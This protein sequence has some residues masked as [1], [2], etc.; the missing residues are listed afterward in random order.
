[1]PSLSPRR[2]RSDAVRCTTIK[3]N[4]ERCG[5]LAGSGG[6]CVLHADPER[7]RELGRKGGQ[8]RERS[9]LGVDAAFQLTDD[10]LRGLA[11]Q[12]LQEMLGSDN[13]QIRARVATALFSYRAG[14]PSVEEQAE[15]QI[16]A[17]W[18][19]FLWRFLES[20][21]SDGLIRYELVE[22]ADRTVLKYAVLDWQQLER[23]RFREGVWAGEAALM[24]ALIEDNNESEATA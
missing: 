5:A 12:T 13:E 15:A 23:V 3:R 8:A 10:G 24:L 11:R 4:G 6:L 21:R 2:K 18:R 1:M 9:V 22:E 19:R 17:G 14:D 7:A 20:L 16:A